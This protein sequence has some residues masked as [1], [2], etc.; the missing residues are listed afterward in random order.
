MLLTGGPSGPDGPPSPGAP[1][2]PCMNKQEIIKNE[3]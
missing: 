3:V 2:S 1:L